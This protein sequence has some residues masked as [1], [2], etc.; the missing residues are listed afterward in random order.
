[1]KEETHEWA[2]QLIDKRH[3]EG[4]TATEY[5]GLEAHLEICAD[6]RKRAR[7]T[8]FALRAL[9]AAVPR[10]DSTLVLRSQMQVRVRALELIEDAA[11]TRALWICCAL[12]WVLGVISAPLMWQGF[13]WIGHRWALSRLVWITGFA[14]AWMAPAA[15]AAAVIAWRQAE[16]AVGSRQ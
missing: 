9:R 16:K 3:V 2:V 15:A 11:R 12:S 14:L 6:C 5:D 1:M 7:E 8:E 4:L 13:Q 10:F